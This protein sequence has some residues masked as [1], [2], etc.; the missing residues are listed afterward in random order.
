MKRR[1]VYTMTNDDR[2]ILID[3]LNRKVSYRELG[4]KLGCSHENVRVHISGLLRQMYE[5]KYIIIK[6]IN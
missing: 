3:W 2:N 1:T 4:E 6:N 5:E